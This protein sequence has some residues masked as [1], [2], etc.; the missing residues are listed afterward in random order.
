MGPD[1]LRESLLQIIRDATRRVDYLRAVRARVVHVL[2]DG[3]VETE[4]E[5]AG[6]SQQPALPLRYGVPGVLRAVARTGARVLVQW[7]EG[8]PAQPYVSAWDGGEELLELVFNTVGGHRA[9]ARNADTAACGMLNVTA[10]PAT[11]GPPASI[12]TLTYTPPGDGATPQV[13]TLAGP[14]GITGT[15][16]VTLSGLINGTSRIQG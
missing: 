9:L 2:A 10:V 5:T 16:A 1:R 6:T 13:I 4:P 3:A 7:A 12:I 11:S 8:D 15:G 14:A